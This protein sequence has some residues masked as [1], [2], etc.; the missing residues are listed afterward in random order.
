MEPEI[1]A[2]AAE[3][4]DVEHVAGLRAAVEAMDLALDNAREYIDA[5]NQF[6]RTLALASRN[7]LILSLVDSVVDLLSEQ[8]SRIFAVAGG[9]ERGQVYHKALL[10]AIE[11]RDH[12]AARDAMRA[13]LRQVRDDVAASLTPGSSPREEV[14]LLN[15]T[16]T[17]DG[18]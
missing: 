15:L 14:T 8:R 10:D 16:A 5:D 9:P 1:A 3:R 4:A 11:R 7:P 17:Q 18:S 13:H 12:R 2:L 6:H